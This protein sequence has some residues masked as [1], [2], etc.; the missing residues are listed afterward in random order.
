MKPSTLTRIT[1]FVL[2]IFS[3]A[4]LI[5]VNNEI[6]TRYNQ[7]DGKTR[8]LFGIVELLEFQYRYLILIPAAL[9]ILL[10]IRLIWTREFKIWDTVTLIF[11]LLSVVGTVTSSWRLMT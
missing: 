7:A 1:P 3:L 6:A 4:A 2:S 11:G 10:T 9:S 5:F 8:A